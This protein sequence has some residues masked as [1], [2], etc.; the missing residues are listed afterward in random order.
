SAVAHMREMLQI[1]R[2]SPLFRLQTADDVMQRLTFHNTGPDQVPGVIVMGLSD[3]VDG[4]E[5]IDPN[6]EMIVVVFNG[7]DEVVTVGDAAF[8]DLAFELHPIQVTSSDVVVQRAVH[9]GDGT[10]TV[11]ARTTAVF[12]VPG[13]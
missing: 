2:S 7:S 1:R 13:A 8:G 11:P 6:H 4:L 9:N 5:S 10:F 3:I 12:V